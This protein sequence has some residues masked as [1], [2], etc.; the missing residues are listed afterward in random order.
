MLHLSSLLSEAAHPEEPLEEGQ[1]C[2]EDKILACHGAQ[3]IEILTDEGG[4]P[5]R[6]IQPAPPGSLA[7]ATGG[8]LLTP[9]HALDRLQKGHN[10]VSEFTPEFDGGRH[11][12][13]HIDRHGMSCRPLGEMR[14][15]SLSPES[16]LYLGEIAT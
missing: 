5:K 16:D 12:G 13:G 9:L 2:V 6:D 3:R 10:T 15:R 8:P 4:Q 14:R 11:K 7:S 1:A